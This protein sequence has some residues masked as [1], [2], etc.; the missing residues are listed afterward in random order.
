MVDAPYKKFPV[1]NV[2]KN[3]LNKKMFKILLLKFLQE[4]EAEWIGLTVDEAVEKVKK[5]EAE[6]NIVQP[7]KELYIT[8]L[9]KTLQGDDVSTKPDVQNVNLSHKKDKEART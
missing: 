5:I 1:I 8:E 7:L 3:Y 4:H 2:K 6:Q 9:V